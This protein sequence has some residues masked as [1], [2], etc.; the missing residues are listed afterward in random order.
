[1]SCYLDLMYIEMGMVI[2]LCGTDRFWKII[3]DFLLDKLK[4]NITVHVCV[5]M[6]MCLW[7]YLATCVFVRRQL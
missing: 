7:A 2:N 1:M 5:S 3:E 4:K 6:S